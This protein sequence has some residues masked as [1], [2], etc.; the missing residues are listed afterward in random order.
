MAVLVAHRLNVQGSAQGT[1]WTSDDG[2]YM[3]IDVTHLPEIIDFTAERATRGVRSTGA[4][5]FARVYELA[6]ARRQRMTGPGRIPEAVWDDITRA[7]ELADD[8][9]AAGRRVRFDTHHL[10]GRVVASLCD[11]DGGLIRR[12]GLAEILDPDPDPPAAA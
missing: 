4:G 8:L 1:A 7:N 11:A 9:A 3:G 10:S 5:E 6:E 12:M 2:Q